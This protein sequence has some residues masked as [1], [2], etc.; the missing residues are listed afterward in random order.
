MPDT[1]DRASIIAYIEARVTKLLDRAEKHPEDA[2]YYRGT[3][4]IFT[5]LIGEIAAEFDRA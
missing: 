5:A 3:A 1:T 4:T 2:S